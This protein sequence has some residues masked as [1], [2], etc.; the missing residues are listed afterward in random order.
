MSPIFYPAKHNSLFIWIWQRLNFIELGTRVK[1]NI[2]PAE[3]KTLSS[4]PESTGLILIA[5]HSDELDPRICMELSRR[6]G[7]R[8]TFMANSD[9]YKEWFGIARWCLQYIGSFSIERG[10]QD[11]QAIRY[12]IDVVK[13][14][15]DV[16]VM[17]PE[18]EIYNLNDSVQPF[19]TG[20]IHIGLEAIKEMYAESSNKTVSILPVAIKYRYQQNIGSIL[21]KRIIRMEKHLALRSNVME[22]REELYRI[23]NK[24][25]ET[26]RPV[27]NSELEFMQ[28]DALVNEL[29]KT[30]ESVV[31]E[32]ERKYADP[33]KPH[34]DLLSRAQK[35]IAF[36]R[37]QMSQEKLFTRETQKQFQE[38]LQALKNTI[39]MATWQPQYIEL[40]PSEEHLAETVIK[41]ERMVFNK[42]RPPLFG[43]REAFIRLLDPVDLSVSLASY[44]EDPSSTS[45]KIAEDLRAKIQQSILE[46]KGL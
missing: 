36:L 31:S 21:R 42:K 33:I 28:V 24:L 2:L 40:D 19:K 9:I 5:N 11:Q 3:I 6:S 38:D 26:V 4:I 7:R 39:Q 1:L 18:G 16:L 17:F 44:E 32:I 8:F 23:M 34:G 30:R 13:K 25:R 10:A 35:M 12:A 45:K 14:T 15:N 37:E 46:M 27:N 29:Q 43:K 22:L 20:A 41:L